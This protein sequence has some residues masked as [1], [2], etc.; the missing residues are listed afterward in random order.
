[1]TNSECK[2]VCST[3]NADKARNFMTCTSC[4]EKQHVGTCSGVKNQQIAMEI[5]DTYL[6]PACLL[7]SGIHDPLEIEKSLAEMD[8]N[9]PTQSSSVGYKTTEPG[10]HHVVPPDPTEDDQLD[11]LTYKE[12]LLIARNCEDNLKS[13][14][15]AFV[16]AKA[17]L[18]LITNGIHDT[19]MKLGS[20]MRK[21]KGK[22]DEPQVDGLKATTAHSQA[23]GLTGSTSGQKVAQKGAERG[24]QNRRRPPVVR[25]SC[26]HDNEIPFEAAPPPAPKKRLFLG[27]ICRGP[28]ATPEGIKDYVKKK[29]ELDV[30]VLQ[31][32]HAEAPRLSFVVEVSAV[33]YDKIADPEIWPLNTH[34]REFFGGIYRFKAKPGGNF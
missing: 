8:R 32:N 30:C 18:S 33:G 20:I 4:R 13:F 5:A 23:T 2:D 25:G 3:C 1:M 27:N 31:T 28:R 19:N 34:I 12:L 15:E 29:T 10:T 7:N 26:P 24:S 6:C 14:K 9:D 17:Q 21:L 11:L 22:V 16:L